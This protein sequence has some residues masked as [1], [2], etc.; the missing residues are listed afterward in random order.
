[1]NLLR[2]FSLLM[3]PALFYGCATAPIMSAAEREN[4]LQRFIGQS[5]TSIQ[6]NLNLENLGYQ[7]ASEPVL[8]SNSLTYTVL[9]P[10]SIPIPM[11]QNPALGSGAG[12][13]VPIQPAQRYDTDLTCQISFQLEQGIAKAVYMSGRTC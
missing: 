7:N 13:A 2:T 5:S 11:A 3:L 4:Y 8:N 1:M 9:R 10:V 6:A 12:T